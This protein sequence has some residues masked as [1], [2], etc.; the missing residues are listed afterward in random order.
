VG[1]LTVAQ[2]LG[3]LTG[4]PV[5]DNHLTFDCVR[6][7]YGLDSP[8]LNP[9]V[10]EIR[11][12]VIGEAARDGISLIFTF[13]YGHPHDIEYVARI[14]DLVEGHGGS[15]DF[16]QLTCGAAEQEAR[17]VSE[18]RIGRKLDSVDGLR[19]WSATRDLTSAI[20][21]RGGLCIDTTTLPAADAAREITTALGL[22]LI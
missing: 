11:H 13:V 19:A 20:P 16:V 12:L 21:D 10:E 4:F 18:H 5:F 1:K 22:P 8:K 6:A 3:R 9:L 15:V 2:E 7:V 17:V 14:C